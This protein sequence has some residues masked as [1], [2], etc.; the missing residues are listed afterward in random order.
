MILLVLICFLFV[1][2]LLKNHLFHEQRYISQNYSMARYKYI[3]PIQTTIASDLFKVCK[4][5]NNINNIENCKNINV[6]ISIRDGS[7]NL[8]IA[9]P[10]SQTK[11]D[12]YIIPDMELEN[13][14][15]TP[16]VG[17]AVL[18]IVNY[19]NYAHG[20]TSKLQLYCQCKYPQLMSHHNINA[21]RGDCTYKNNCAHNGTLHVPQDSNSKYMDPLIH[22]RCSCPLAD[23]V[24]YHDFEN[25][26]DCRYKTVKDFTPYEFNNTF[27][28]ETIDNYK[29]NAPITPSTS[30]AIIDY[31]KPMFL[32]KKYIDPE[33][34]AEF[35]DDGVEYALPNPCNYDYKTGERIDPSEVKVML[36]N[37]I[38]TCVVTKL[39]S[40]YVTLITDTDYLLNNDGKYPNAVMNVAGNGDY[41][42]VMFFPDKIFS[43]LPMIGTMVLNNDDNLAS[44][45]SDIGGNYY[46]RPRLPGNWEPYCNVLARNKTL[47]TNI[48][49]A[50]LC[51]D[52]DIEKVYWPSYFQNYYNNYHNLRTCEHY[53]SLGL[54]MG[55][56]DKLDYDHE[57]IDVCLTEE[58]YL[59][60]QGRLDD[61]LL[62]F[63]LNWPSKY[64]NE[65]NIETLYNF[66]FSKMPL[67]YPSSS[68]VKT[69]TNYNKL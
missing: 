41:Y 4:I 69:M 17:S 26:P 28:P 45:Q 59:Q 12:G 36:I 66:D 46:F 68:I 42:A 55:T 27:F 11:E 32:E 39:T 18:V 8:I 20:G 14:E 51:Y 34:L 56:K 29:G 2:E 43:T 57:V 60:Y 3:K 64:T 40:K 47:G 53:K 25:G 1:Y 5:D 44:P 38:A 7:G 49:Y 63:G 65:K 23:T 31:P 35:L 52:Q 21:I 30:T 37:N 50:G 48:D 9:L 24:A 15:C 58:G 67:I 62:I 16:S 10:P 61:E 6:P 33:F 54:T 13:F 22:G 19:D